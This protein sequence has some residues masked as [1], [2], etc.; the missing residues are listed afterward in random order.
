MSEEPQPCC[1]LEISVWHEPGAA[2]EVHTLRCGPPGGD[3]PAAERACALLHTE[4][5][6]PFA[7][8]PPGTFSAQ[9]FGGPQR[10]T[11]RGRW[12]GTPVS[13][14]FS[15]HNAA[16]MGRWSRAVPVLPDVTAR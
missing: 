6:D 2:P 13:A 12:H 11:V 14:S 8:V 10:A 5:V 1:E 7:P 16:E 15:R 9:V 4:G 3:H